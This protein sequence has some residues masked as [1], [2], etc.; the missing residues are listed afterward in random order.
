M[1]VHTLN[2]SASQQDFLKRLTEECA[3][4]GVTMRLNYCNFLHAREIK[5]SSG[6]LIKIDRGLDMYMPPRK[7]GNGN[8]TPTV[9]CSEGHE[10]L[11]VCRKRNPE[12]IDILLD[13]L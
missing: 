10:F 3:T 7:G 4:V 1:G 12:K 13:V 9:L 2:E 5:F 11:R 6:H 8:A